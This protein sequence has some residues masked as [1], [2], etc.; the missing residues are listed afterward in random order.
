MKQLA[1]HIYVHDGY[2]G[3]T[4][5]CVITPLGPICIDSPTLA[6]DARDWR[7]RIAKVSAL[8]VRMVVL[9]D[10]HRDRILGAQYLGG[11]V[12][13]HDL[14][15]DKIKSLGDTIRQPTADSNTP[16]GESAAIGSDARLVLPQI[17]FAD[18]LIIANGAAPLVVQHVGG[19]TPGSL[20]VHLPK[21]GVLFMGDAAVHDAHPLIGEAEI[22]VWLELLARV[23]APEFPAR[24][25]VPG[26][27]APCD[28]DALEPLADYLNTMVAR[29]Q[30]FIRARKPKAE[31][32]QL[33]P[34]LLAR[35][36][37]ADADRD[38]A[39]RRIRAGLERLYDSLK[40]KK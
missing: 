34:E 26:R 18:K 10:A 36:P 4:V 16:C 7:A 33:A 15:W 2:H 25:I 27:G 13:A 39:Q 1:P 28:K 40:A 9:T 37:V 11:V 21:P 30:A 32:A 5:G 29:V 19:V 12:V 20:W 31:L 35:F 8:P 38:C 23:Q 3:V 24:R 17:T 6:S 22:A 14:T